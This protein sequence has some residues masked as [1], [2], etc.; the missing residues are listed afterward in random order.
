MRD[1]VIISQAMDLHT[2][3]LKAEV[4]LLAHL[5][6]GPRRGVP[7]L[8]DLG[9]GPDSFANID[10]LAIYLAVTYLGATTTTARA[11]LAKKLLASVDR[12]DNQD[13]RPF[14]TFSHC[15]GPGPLTALLTRLPFEQGRLQR[16]AAELIQLIDVERGQSTGER[17][18]DDEQQ[19]EAAH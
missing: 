5:A 2:Q 14:V 1:E 18:A 7:I 13:V 11:Q 17:S 9:I 12:W 3:R 15:W 16:A 4:E 6:G 8:N 10:T 19:D